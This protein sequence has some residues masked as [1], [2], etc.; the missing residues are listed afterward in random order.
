MKGRGVKFLLSTPTLTLPRQRGRD[1]LGKFQI[2][3]FRN[4]RVT[5]VF[6]ESEVWINLGTPEVY[7][8]EV[9]PCLRRSGFA[10]AGLNLSPL[11]CVLLY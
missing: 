8:A 9:P 3:L 6:N 2:S 4:L 1:I 11:T 5:F 7:S 10:Q